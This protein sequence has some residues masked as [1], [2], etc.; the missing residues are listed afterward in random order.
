MY[1]AL[2]NQLKVGDVFLTCVKG[3]NPFSLFIK[4]GNFFKRGYKDR[5]WT[6]AAIY[7]GDGKVAE[8]FPKGIVVRD[9]KEAYLNGNYELLVLRH[10]NATEDKLRKAANFCA[11]ADKK[12]Y[13]SRALIYFLLYNITPSQIHFI[14]EN[15]FIGKCFN[16][17]DSYFCSELVSN[18]FLDAG[19]YCFQKEPYKIMP[20]EFYNDLIFEKAAELKLP[21]G[22]RI[23]HTIKAF[24]FWITYSISSLLFLIIMWLIALL[25]IVLLAL[26]GLGLV[27]I[28][29]VIIGSLKKATAPVESKPDENNKKV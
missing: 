4:V 7:I 15:D 13:D 3:V 16:V 29:V 9:F 17:N 12:P 24:L 19:L 2:L 6:H 22:N 1:E 8:A 20:V 11:N 27:S 10:K 21:Q 14:W 23:V 26:V 5:G 25:A 28:V 18:G